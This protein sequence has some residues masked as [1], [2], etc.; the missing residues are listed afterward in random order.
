MAS[1]IVSRPVP[2][3]DKD[4]GIL[5]ETFQERY[6]GGPHPRIFLLMLAAVAFVLLIACANVANMMLSARWA[7]NARSLFAPPWRVAL[8]AHCQFC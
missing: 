8:A 1:P 3:A 2:D 6:N 4:L 5:V 7:A